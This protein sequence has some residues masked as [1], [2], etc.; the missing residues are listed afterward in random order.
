MDIQFGENPF[1]WIDSRRLAFAVLPDGEH[2][3]YHAFSRGGIGRE[4]ILASFDGANK[5]VLMKDVS[6]VSVSGSTTIGARCMIGGASTP[7]ARHF[8]SLNPRRNRY[9]P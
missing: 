1:V 6:D 7:A 8:C 3:V 5:K 2:L 9:T 4:L